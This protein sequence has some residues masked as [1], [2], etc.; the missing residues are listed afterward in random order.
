MPRKLIGK[1]ERDSSRNVNVLQ[2]LSCKSLSTIG[3]SF[4]LMGEAIL[5]I[6]GS[7]DWYQRLIAAA[8]NPARTLVFDM[9]SVEKIDTACLQLLTAFVFKARANN[10][11]LTWHEPSEHFLAA[12]NGLN[13]NTALGM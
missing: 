2:T 6:S 5:T 3:P 9:S 12:I 10:I 4:V 11:A 7:R 1:N 13:L 8:A